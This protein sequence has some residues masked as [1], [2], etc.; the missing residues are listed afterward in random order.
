MLTCND[1]N[2]NEIRRDINTEETLG[3]FKPNVYIDKNRTG[4][5]I[6]EME[7]NGLGVSIYW[8][9]VFDRP[10]LDVFFPQYID[11]PQHTSHCEYMMKGPCCAMIIEG[12]N[13]LNAW[14]EMARVYNDKNDTG[15]GFHACFSKEEMERE[16]NILIKYIKE[17]PI[18]Y[19]QPNQEGKE[20]N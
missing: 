4:E 20:D 1:D 12:K 18:E 10:L 5:I 8:E 3:I 19:L 15:N 17:N 16:C 11:T 6:Q 7:S 9:V 13:A 2:K 14:K